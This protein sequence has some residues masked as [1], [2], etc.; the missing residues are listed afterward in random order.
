MYSVC[1]FPGSSNTR[2][3]FLGYC[4]PPI[5]RTERLQPRQKARPPHRCSLLLYSATYQ[6]PC[7]VVPHPSTWLLH[8]TAAHGTSP[9][10]HEQQQRRAQK[11]RLLLGRP[12]QQQLPPRQSSHATSAQVVFGHGFR[13][14]R[15]QQTPHRRRPRNRVLQPCRKIPSSQLPGRPRPTMTLPRIMSAWI[16]VRRSP[17]SRGR[18]DSYTLQLPISPVASVA[19]H[20]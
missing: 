9:R 10:Q 13:H 5:R 3:P 4:Q 17:P 7:T 1:R 14:R 19:S 11:P 6:T 2:Q 16:P 18:G 8:C 15:K 12:L 20:S